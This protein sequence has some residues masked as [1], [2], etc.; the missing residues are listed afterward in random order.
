MIGCV[1]I[2][3]PKSKLGLAIDYAIKRWPYLIAY[4]ED[5]RREIDNNRAERGIKPFVMGRKN[6]LFANTMGGAHASCH[7][8]S[9]IETAKANNIN[10]NQYLE[11]IFK[12]LA[13]CQSIEDYK[14]LLPWNVNIGS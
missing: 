2:C 4:I 13:L 8:F 9:L 1:R 11:H 12:E 5:G 10:P 14:N 3:I 6:W 7:L